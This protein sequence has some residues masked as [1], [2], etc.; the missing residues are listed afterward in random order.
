M[1][2]LARKLGFVN[3]VCVEAI[4]LAGGSCLMWN[5]NINLVIN[6]FAEG[7]F[8][9]T[10]WDYQFQLHWKL[11][12]VYGTPY[13]EVKET[14]WSCLEEEISQCQLPWLLLGD[15]NCI[16]SQEEKVG[17]RKV[18][19]NDTR[20]LRNFMENTGSVDLQFIGNKFTWQ[21]NR[22]SGGLIRERLDRAICSPE[23]LMNF[24]SAGVRNLPISV[25]DHAPIIL[26]SHLFAVKGFIPFHFFEAWSWEASCKREIE[27]VW[28]SSGV[29]ATASFIRNIHYSKT[30]L[31]SWK[32]N[33][34]GTDERYIKELE[35][36]LEWIQSQPL[37]DA[38][39][40]EE[41]R[42]HSQLSTS[43][44]KLESMW[45]QKS[46]ETWLS[47]G[48]RNTSFFHAA[49]VIRK[50]RN[51][52]WA[53]K[54]KDGRVW[55]DKKH[56]A[57]V[58]NAYF[59]DLFTSSNP[60]LEDD[61]IGLLDK[62]LDTTA[63]ESFADI[64]S[65]AEIKGAVFSLHPL[66]APGPD[67]FSGCF[68]RKYWD[69]VGSNLCDTVKEFFSSGNM[70]PKLNNTFICLIP[71]V[72]FPMSVDQFRPISLCNFSYKVIAKILSNR[73]RPLTNDLV[74]PY[75]SA[76]IPG[77]WIAE[78]SIL[79]QEIIH[80]IKNKRGLGGLMALKLDMHKAY[81][82][83]EWGF[84]EK[85][86]TA[87]GFD[88][89]SKKLVMACVTSVSYSVLL[90]GCPLRKLK[91]QRGLRQGDSLSPFLFLLCQEVLSK[92]ISR[93]EEGGGIHGIKIAY[94]APPVSHL[95]FADDTI[96]FARANESEAKKLIDCISAY[97]DW[98]GQKCSK[99]K[100]SIL[101]S[102]NLN[103]R[104]RDQILSILNIDQ[105][106]GDE[107][108]LGNPFVFK[109]RKKEDYKRLK[110]SLM[111]K[112]E[113][114]KMKLLSYAGRLTLIKS[115]TSA[116]PVYAMSTSKI[117]LSTCRELDSLMR[118]FWWLGN[119]EKSRYV[120]LKAWDKICQPKVSGGL[121]LRKCE[122]MNQALLSKL[123]WS[124]ANQEGRPWVKCLLAKY[125]K[126]ESFWSV[127]PR[128]SDSVQWRCILDSRQTI[129]KG[130]ISIAASGHSINFWYQPWIPWLEYQEFTILMHALRSRGYTIKTLG[131]VSIENAWNEEV[132]LQIFG[133]EM[134]NRIINI[135]RIPSP[136]S[137]Q[138]FWKNNKKGSFSVKGAYLVENAQN[139]DQVK[140]IWKRIW[141]VGIHPR[142]S[143]LLWRILNDAI[144]I[145]SRLHF[146][147]DKVCSLCGAE[148]E[149]V[150]HLFWKCSFTR[151]I[152]FGGILPLRIEDIPADDFINL[153]DSLIDL[154]KDHSMSR[155]EL[156]NIIGCICSEIWQQRNGLCIRNTS[157]NAVAA[158]DRIKLQIRNL[159]T[160]PSPS[161]LDTNH[162]RIS[163]ENLPPQVLVARACNVIFSDASWVKGGAGIAAVS[164]DIHNGTW[165]V[166]AQ[167]IQAQSALGAEFSAIFLALNRAVELGWHQ[168]HILSDSNIA[169][170]SLT[171]VEVPDW[172]IASIFYSI[173]NVSKNF[174]VCNFFFINRSLNVV[175]DGAAKKARLA[176]D[177]A[178]LY[179]GEGDPL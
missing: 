140:L 132:I 110:D 56:I 158:L 88:D 93:E 148:E 31:Q 89:R 13:S 115:V 166:K 167:K 179:Q 8:E 62:K 97:E 77:R 34:V 72:D 17:G 9:A 136:H 32:K 14:F 126:H 176:S 83:M 153:M 23:W 96:L 43:W 75:Q 118:K 113:G 157:A 117:P 144:P 68:F 125:C 64:P 41:A 44:A 1:E 121:G 150:M 69:I 58:I 42:I 54:D 128:S 165:F 63:N 24:A 46:R 74:S 139:F 6:Y 175:A 28:V 18:S 37:S 154:F 177:L 138:I 92:L 49:T 81:D 152:W 40:V 143:V 3:I 133:I 119:V 107:R 127:K 19:Y 94:S 100:S 20:W 45:R 26:D 134:G 52:I 86:L 131:D 84:L 112:L 106:R 145:K 4:G 141:D 22:F 91:P 120:A 147:Q 104:R 33:L 124:L 50:R 66:K 10:V 16:Y 25:S 35:N 169:V 103:G 178:C 65:D 60:N 55:K 163:P 122:D 15:L 39:S 151:A 149:N 137:D 12:T 135:P 168:I 130:S 11:Y 90:N 98:S 109:R 2:V 95:M 67:G 27:T 102:K 73:L 164:V 47:L 59:L 80:K 123:A 174:Q 142:V 162:A 116:M 61:L 51:N 78:S 38:L 36:K 172:R 155:S 76:F 29:N 170:Q 87:V 79:T 48:D 101:F 70:H 57:E 85:V 160:V 82:R 53:I 111:K 146:L 105:V 156:L 5:N 30:A 99:P 71:K 161:N 129:L 108:H 173:V 21:N 114:W 159:Q 171:S 7:F